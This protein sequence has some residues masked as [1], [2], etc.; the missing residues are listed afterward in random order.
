MAEDGLLRGSCPPVI[1]FQS[2]ERI[3]YI[4]V[5]ILKIFLSIRN[6]DRHRKESRIVS[7]YSILD[8]EVDF[9]PTGGIYLQWELGR[10]LDFEVFPRIGFFA[11]MWNS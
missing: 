3:R 1:F 11:W 4:M 10:H 5:R 6:K 9:I 2:R 7:P 8:Y